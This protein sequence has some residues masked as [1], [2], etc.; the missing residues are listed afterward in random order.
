MPAY[1][2]HADVLV[3]PHVVTPFTDSLDPIKLYEYQAAGRPV[4]STPVAGFRDAVD[5]LV[6]VADAAAFAEPSWTPAPAVQG[7]RRAHRDARPIR[8]GWRR[9]TGHAGSTRWST[10]SRACAPGVYRDRH[11]H[12]TPWEVHVRALGVTVE[13][14]VDNAELVAPK[15]AASGR[16]A[17][18]PDRWATDASRGTSSRGDHA[19]AGSSRRRGRRGAPAPPDAGG[20]PGGDRRRAGEL[21]M[22]HAGA[23]S[24][25]DTGAS[26]AFVAP[27]GT[28]KTTL[29]RTLGRGRGYV[30]DET[31]GVRARRARSSPTASRCR[32]DV[33]VH[34]RPK[35]ETSPLALALSMPRVTPWL[36]GMVVLRRDL[37]PGRPV[38]LEKVDLLDALVTL[39]P[40][41]SSLAALRPTPQGTGRH[42]T[43]GGRRARSVALPRRRRIVEPRCV[44]DGAG[45]G[46]VT[47][48][49]PR[50]PTV[51]RRGDT[52]ARPARDA[53][54]GRSSRGSRAAHR[55]VRLSVLGVA[56][57]RHGVRRTFGAPSTG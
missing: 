43:V 3:V 48:D 45:D 57:P 7:P 15:S 16:P 21:L 4:V 44:H 52:S 28:G 53:R 42:R 40:E 55:I 46:E 12:P 29:V 37:R 11:G 8:S 36:A 26:I 33:R 18:V 47:G 51:V 49:A 31:V 34:R 24:D 6:T 2:Q 25:Q 10:S 14:V 50:T 1:L 39:G 35:D 41:T 9:S 22:F 17:W 20:D 56:D 30:T 5:E 27:G 54:L 13:I 23:L 32:C 38:E 19:H